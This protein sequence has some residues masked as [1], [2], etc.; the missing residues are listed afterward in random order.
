MS[1]LQKAAM[2]MI[3]AMIYSVI[4]LALCA[5][6]NS[7]TTAAKA[8]RFMQQH[9]EVSA[10]FCAEAYPVRDSVGVDSVSY[11]PADNTDYTATIDSLLSLTD[12]LFDANRLRRMIVD[13]AG[14]IESYY[15]LQL[16]RQ[17]KEARRLKE[18]LQSFRTSYRPCVPDT[19]LI[20]RQHWLENTA[21]LE[22]SEMSCDVRIAAL[23]SDTARLGGVMSERTARLK[24]AKEG[25]SKWRLWCLL[26]WAAIGGYTFLKIRFKMPF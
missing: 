1:R 26:T 2:W 13:T 4:I 15:R 22:A 25:L 21:R 6:L 9:P 23:E 12:S 5:L 24:E 16:L 10:Q 11:T 20:L 8:T 3:L 17:Q 18:A 7:C 14:L 19:A